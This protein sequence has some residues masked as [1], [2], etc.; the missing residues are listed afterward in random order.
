MVSPFA[1]KAIDATFFL[2]FTRPRAVI[3]RSST[4]LVVRKRAPVHASFAKASVVALVTAVAGSNLSKDGE[5]A[6]EIA[7]VKV[8]LPT[9]SISASKGLFIYFCTLFLYWGSSVRKSAISTKS[10]VWLIWLS[11]SSTIPCYVLNVKS[12]L[13]I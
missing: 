11:Y 1:S 9:L 8:P 7:T 10:S 3:L 13:L 2:S 5:S 4:F 6:F 12:S